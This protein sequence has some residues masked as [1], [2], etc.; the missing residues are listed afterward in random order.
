MIHCIQLYLQNGLI[1]Q[2]AKNIKVRKFIAETSMEFLDWAE[3]SV[4]LP[5]NR[6]N[7]KIEFYE[8]FTREYK[9]FAKWLTRKKFNIWIKKYAT[10]I[11][12]EYSEGNSL[13]SRWFTIGEQIVEEE[14]PF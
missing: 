11:N 6:R 4:N 13:G 12:K 14:T 8:L 5:H 2:D 3:D 1:K 10:F 9:D 7:D